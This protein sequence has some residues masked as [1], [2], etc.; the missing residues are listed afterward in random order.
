LVRRV[1]ATYSDDI[2]QLLKHCRILDSAG[3]EMLGLPNVTGPIFCPD[4]SANISIVRELSTAAWAIAMMDSQGSHQATVVGP[5][6]WPCPETAQGSEQIAM[7]MSERIAASTHENSAWIHQDALTLVNMASS[8][9]RHQLA[10]SKVYS[11]V[12]RAVQVKTNATWKQNDCHYSH[13]AAHRTADEIDVL[14]QCMRIPAIGNSIADSHAVE[15]RQ[16]LH[17]E[18][19]S[20]SLQQAEVFLKNATRVA[21]VV[22]KTLSVFPKN[23]QSSR[24]MPA[25]VNLSAK[26][27]AV[28]HRILRRQ[29]AVALSDR[30]HL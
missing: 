21:K 29:H 30:E 1:D 6:F 23:D 10:A 13:V 25:P 8:T 27:E 7:M 19:C 11:G 16:A 3:Q 20:E 24:V 9:I 2:A 14:P 15:H 28:Q 26:K 5:V 17:Q 12:R 18:L 22:A 4:G